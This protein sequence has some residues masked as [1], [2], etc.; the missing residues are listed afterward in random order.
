LH[1][2]DLNSQFVLAN[3]AISQPNFIWEIRSKILQ[4]NLTAHAG[5][6]NHKSHLRRTLVA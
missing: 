6:S 4:Q 5:V 3:R 2:A 1:V